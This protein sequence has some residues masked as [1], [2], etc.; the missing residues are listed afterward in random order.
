MLPP[1]PPEPVMAICG[2]TAGAR[3]S[4]GSPIST[5]WS[6]ELWQ[7]GLLPTRHPGE[8]VLEPGRASCTR[9]GWAEVSCPVWTGRG[10]PGQ[11]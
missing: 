4:R 2:D 10:S 9:Q 3:P 11:G 8:K 5:V 6:W 1:A 7:L